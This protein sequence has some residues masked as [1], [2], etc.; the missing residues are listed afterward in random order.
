MC[1]VAGGLQVAWCYLRDSLRQRFEIV[2]QIEKHDAVSQDNVILPTG[3]VCPGAIY[4][5]PLCLLCGE[6][7]F[8][9]LEQSCDSGI[10]SHCG[11]AEKAQQVGP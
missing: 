8:F 3:R 9:H 4:A 7:C 10:V 5:F 6:E 11:L 2:R 1:C